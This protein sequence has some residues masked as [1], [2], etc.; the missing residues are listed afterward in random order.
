DAGED[1]DHCAERGQ[2]TAHEY[3]RSTPARVESSD[4]LELL[5]VQEPV[6]D[7][8]R[9]EGAAVA[10]GERVDQECTCDVAYPCDQ[11]YGHGVRPP[12]RGEKCPEEHEGVGGDRRND[13]LHRGTAAEDQVEEQRPEIIQ[14]ADD[15]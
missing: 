11:E 2:E 8:G 1:R 9:E 6:A 3:R 7:R 15:I 12:R 14:V 13:V 10:A 4:R 5:R